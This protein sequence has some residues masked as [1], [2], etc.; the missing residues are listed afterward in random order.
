MRIILRRE[1]LDFLIESL[2]ATL[3]PY[4]RLSL[5]R[6]GVFLGPGMLKH[7]HDRGTEHLR[8]SLVT[9]P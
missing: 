9:G 5:P 7:I 4:L 6:L 1:V 3:G 8:T 2:I